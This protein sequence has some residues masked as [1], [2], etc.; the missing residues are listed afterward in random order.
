MKIAAATDDNITVTG[1]VGR[2]NAFI[3]YTIDGSQIIKKEIIEN[4]FTH[5]Q[6]HGHSHDEKEHSHGHSHSNLIDALKECEAL[7]FSHGGWRLVEDLKKNNIKP[8]MTDVVN[9]DEAA[10]KY[11]AGELRS[12]EENVCNHH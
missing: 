2:C 6:V 10:A 8:I 5:H 1:H 3:I 11:I 7:I 4:K 12:N 9:A